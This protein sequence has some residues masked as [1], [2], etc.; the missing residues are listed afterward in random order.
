MQNTIDAIS[1]LH[2]REILR[3]LWEG[4]GMSSGEIARRLPVTW[5]STSRNLKVLRTAGLVEETRLGT[6]RYYRANREALRPLE[7][8][9][10]QMWEQNL[11]QIV[12]L[13]EKE[14]RGKRRR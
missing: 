14:Q 4:D 5:Q 8:L 2:R 7:D 3:L 13:S 1:N 10:H 6:Q 11:D 9:L 12:A